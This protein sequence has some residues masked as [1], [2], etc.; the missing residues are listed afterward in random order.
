MTGVSSTALSCE[1]CAI[2]V[3][4]SF[5]AAQLYAMPSYEV[6]LW[7]Q[8]AEQARAIADRVD[9]PG[10]KRTMLVIAMRYDVMALW[11]AE[12]DRIKPAE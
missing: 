7:A 10:L 12:A 6:S 4:F 11:V 5:W 9:N 8:L 1:G 2:R 3:D